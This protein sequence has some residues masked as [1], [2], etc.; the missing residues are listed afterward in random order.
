MQPETP[1]LSSCSPQRF[2]ASRSRGFT[3]I[4][5]LVV[6]LVLGILTILILALIKHQMEPEFPNRL[7]GIDTPTEATVPSSGQDSR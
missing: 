1:N 6:L 4:E 5:S 3:I 7:D 2:P